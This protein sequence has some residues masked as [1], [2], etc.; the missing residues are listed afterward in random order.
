MCNARVSRISGQ[1]VMMQLVQPSMDHF[2]FIATGIFV[3]VVVVVAACSRESVEYF[4]PSFC[5][6]TQ[7]TLMRA[8][9]YAQRTVHSCGGLFFKQL[10]CIYASA[11]VAHNSW[12]KYVIL[13]F[14]F[15]FLFLKIFDSISDRWLMRYSHF[16]SASLDDDGLVN[17]W[18]NTTDNNSINN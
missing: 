9:T 15:F 13:I 7:H 3:V 18:I 2:S 12:K 16:W 5:T 10:L 17:E 4:F 1:A 6:H 14:C 11:F 8:L